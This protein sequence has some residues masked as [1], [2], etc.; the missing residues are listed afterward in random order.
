LG[1][2]FYKN[3]GS[4]FPIF[5]SVLQ[6]FEEFLCQKDLSFIC[7]QGL[8]KSKKNRVFGKLVLIFSSISF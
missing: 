6:V 7:Y 3:L 8:K 4:Y 5:T 1:A 2:V